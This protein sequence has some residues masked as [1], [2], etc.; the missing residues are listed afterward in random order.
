MSRFRR[1]S[2]RPAII[3][4][5]VLLFAS[6]LLAQD[7][8]S[9]TPH[10]NHLLHGSYSFVVHG[11]FFDQPYAASGVLTF[12]G[13]GTI[14]DGSATFVVNGSVVSADL[15]LDQSST[16]LV[17]SDGSGTMR[18]FFAASAGF[19][20]KF[21]TAVTNNGQQIYLNATGLRSPFTFEDTIGP[22]ATGEASQQ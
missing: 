19:G 5:A 11:T 3:S 9:R 21:A 8:K 20:L 14:T 15:M 16:Y 6:S 17:N 1:A 22:T 13:S 12:D 7:A 4:F 18:V 2:M 10:K